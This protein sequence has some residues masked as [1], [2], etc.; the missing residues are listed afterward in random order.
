MTIYRGYDVDEIDDAAGEVLSTIDE[1]SIDP[2]LAL[3]ALCRAIVL[4]G[5]QNSLDMA[6]RIIDELSEVPQA[7]E[8]ID[9]DD[10]D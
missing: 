6:C 8:V 4:M 10:Y 7:H 5:D 1:L 9:Y 3:F 2:K